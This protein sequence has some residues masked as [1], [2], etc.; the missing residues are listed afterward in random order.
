[1]KSMR[2]EPTLQF[3]Q[4]C[5]LRHYIFVLYDNKEDSIPM[6]AEAPVISASLKLFSDIIIH[7]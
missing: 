5:S 6:P 4:P 1:M 3:I 7:N 2:N